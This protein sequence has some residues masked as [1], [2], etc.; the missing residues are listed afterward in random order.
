[1]LTLLRSLL[2]VVLLPMVAE[3]QPAGRTYRIGVLANALDTSD[4]PPFRGFVERLR[5]LGYEDKSV[6]IEWRSSEGDD[7]QLPELAADLVRAKVDV[8]FA[9]S[10][11]PARAAVQAT[12]TVPIVFVVGT[13][14]VA[15]QLVT[16]LA[17]P[18]GNATGLFV[19]RP[20]ET[21]EKVLQLLKAAVPTLSLLAVLTNPDN[22]VQREIMAQ[23]LPAAA[24]RAKVTLMPLTVQSPSEI[25]TAFDAASKR[26]AGAV[27]VLGDVLTF[28]QRGQI[29]DL[30]ARSRLP[31]VYAF[32]GAAEAGG[33]MSYGPDFRELFRRA[34]GYVDKILKGAKPGDLP[35]ESSTKFDLLINLK[36][37]RAIGLALSPAL[38]R[39]ADQV[40]E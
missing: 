8:L 14:P 26:S 32:R 39:Q 28:I 25:S 24:Q 20:Q 27:Y 10:L 36:A 1:M 17:R 37:A 2:L 5:G 11:R 34:A 30:A 23:P 16:S 12:K 35:V 22:R 13:D 18:G 9:T 15:Q 7:G 3:A 21:S 40:I 19:Y 33:L 6:V 31:A 4:G 38:I 29:I